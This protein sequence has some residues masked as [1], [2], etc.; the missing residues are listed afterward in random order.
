MLVSADGMGRR[1]EA[2]APLGA[3]D[4]R[5][6]ARALLLQ[7]PEQRNPLAS[8]L[9]RRQA[10][11]SRPRLRPLL[12]ARPHPHRPESPAATGSPPHPGGGG[13]L[14]RPKNSRGMGLPGG[15]APPPPGRAPSRAQTSP[16]NGARGDARPPASKPP[17]YAPWRYAWLIPVKDLLQAALWL[18]AFLGNH[19][20]WRGQDR[21]S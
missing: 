15:P 7:P 11:R 6:P 8:P 10:R 16:E 1:L 5:L 19:I 21:K 13:G 2:S 14:A 20:E 18:L 4:S 3:H 17:S 12:L 9:A